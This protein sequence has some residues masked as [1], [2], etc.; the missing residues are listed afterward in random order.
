[1]ATKIYLSERGAL[2][3]ETAVA[4]KDY[5]HDD[6]TAFTVEA[7]GNSIYVRLNNVRIMGP[8]IYTD[9]TLADGVTPAGASVSLVRK[10]I[11]T[12]LTTSES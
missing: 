4:R 10:Y 9:I 2:T 11:E 3:I 8:V 12:L 7:V 5:L 1:M 6:G